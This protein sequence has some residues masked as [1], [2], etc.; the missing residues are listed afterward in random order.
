MQTFFLKRCNNTLIIRFLIISAAIVFLLCVYS[1]RRTISRVNSLPP[2]LVAL[3]SRKTV[4]V[5]SS[6]SN[7]AHFNSLTE[8]GLKSCYRGKYTC[9]FTKDRHQ[10]DTHAIL[11]D[12]ASASED[13]PEDRPGPYQR[14]VFVS[15]KTPVQIWLDRSMAFKPHPYQLT[16]LDYKFNWTMTY[17]LDSDVHAPVMMTKKR[18]K[19]LSNIPNHPK[20]TKAVVWFSGNCDAFEFMKKRREW[21]RKL[22]LTVDVDMFGA[23]GVEDPCLKNPD[24]FSS[25]SYDLKQKYH[26]ILALEPAP[27]HGYISEKFWNALKIGLVPV[28][29]GALKQD[30]VEQ[31][32]PNSFIHVNDFETVESLGEYLMKLSE[33]KNLYMKFHEWRKEYFISDVD[34]KCRLCKKLHQESFATSTEIKRKSYKLSDWWSMKVT[35]S[36]RYT[37]HFGDQFFP[38]PYDN[39]PDFNITRKNRIVKKQEKL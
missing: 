18:R 31:A 36:S 11:V 30:Y 39:L 1:L 32:P 13:M 4:L 29:L 37:R 21:V 17:R 10:L 8:S 26:F 15:H 14:W 22:S 33:N 9:E 12:A 24:K 38:L 23:C 19:L 2:E 28:V 6:F 34:I 5:W 20:R 3:A 25:C 7:A 27:C 16:H 35:C